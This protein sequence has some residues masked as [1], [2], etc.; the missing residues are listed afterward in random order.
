MKRYALMKEIV[1]KMQSWYAIRTEGKDPVTK[2]EQICI[3]L[4]LS[5]AHNGF[6]RRKGSLG[7][8]V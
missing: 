1:G 7:K 6:N 2:S 8:R 4:H 5:F 3:Y